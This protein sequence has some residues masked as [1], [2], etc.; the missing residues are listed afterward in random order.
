MT[1]KTISPT[2]ADVAREAGVS[3]STV[4]RILNESPLVADQT[5][6]K[7]R[8]A[9]QRLGYQPRSAARNLALR[10][11]NTLGVLLESVGSSFFASVVAG[12]EEEAYTEGFSLLIATSGHLIRGERP[13][14]GPSNTDGLLI[15]GVQMKK[16]LFSFCQDGYPI[17]SLYQPAP[18]SLHIP[19]ISVE[20]KK[21]AFKVVEHLIREHD[22]SRIAF[23]RGPKGNYDSYWR[24]AGYRQAMKKYGLDVNEELVGDG[25][26]VYLGARA[27]VLH[28]ISNDCLPQAI[29]AGNDDAALDVILTLYG[30]GVRVPQDVAVVGFDDSLLAP[31]MVPPLTTVRAPGLEVGREAAR[32]LLHLIHTGESAPLTLLPTELVIRS[33]CGCLPMKESDPW[34][35]LP[36]TVSLETTGISL[37]SVDERR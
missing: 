5:L 9:I 22:F 28:W 30:A 37:S 16:N 31:N 10:R 14:I 34:A 21:G 25:G 2:I 35:D 33:S 24:E 19:L 23:L 11:T 27:T 18:R 3:I 4:S 32:Q 29:F 8:D 13:A 36:K 20:N 26:F 6:G 17:I 1:R 15:V 7:V 12:A